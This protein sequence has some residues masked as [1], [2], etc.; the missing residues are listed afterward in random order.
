[1]SPAAV[2]DGGYRWAC[3]TGLCVDQGDVGCT[4]NCPAPVSS[5]WTGT[6]VPPRLCLW[7][8]TYGSQTAW[9]VLLKPSARR[10]GGPLRL[11]RS[12]LST[13]ANPV[14]P[15]RCLTLSLRRLA[16]RSPPPSSGCCSR[17]C[18]TALSAPSS[19]QRPRPASRARVRP[20][21]QPVSG[22][23]RLYGWTAAGA[24]RP[25]PVLVAN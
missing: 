13:R 23:T 5:A 4:S 10:H 18:G 7:G 3:D 1:M 19:S 16:S 21:T 8:A 9:H 22:A 2:D 12:V 6:C 20:S 17:A 25:I 14:C 24:N 11:R 15:S